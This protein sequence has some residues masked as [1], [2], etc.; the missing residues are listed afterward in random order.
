MKLS[1]GKTSP[2]KQ[3]LANFWLDFILTDHN[4]FSFPSAKKMCVQLGGMGGS[5]PNS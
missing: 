3:F 1:F 4:N 5:D 2:N